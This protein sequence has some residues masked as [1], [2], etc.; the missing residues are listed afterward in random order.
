MRIS[1]KEFEKRFGFASGV[2]EKKPSKFSSFKTTVDGVIFASRGEAGRYQQ[3]KLLERTGHISNLELQPKYEI[4]ING[5]LI[6]SYYADFRYLENGKE[7]VE[8]FKGFKTPA[9]NL[10]KRLMYAMFGIKIF[11][12]NRK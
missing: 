7:V 12:S 5:I 6:C 4:R 1:V 3:L 8:D 11:E 10:K 2:K 9:Y